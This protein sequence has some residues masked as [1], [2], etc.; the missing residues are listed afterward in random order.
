MPNEYDDDAKEEY[1]DV[2][3]LLFQ[4]VGEVNKR[5]AKYQLAAWNL[6]HDTWGLLHHKLPQVVGVDDTTPFLAALPPAQGTRVNIDDISQENTEVLLAIA[7]LPNCR[8]QILH[9]LLP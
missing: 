4:L 7:A 3:K 5:S 1:D 6:V 9:L 8:L 2:K